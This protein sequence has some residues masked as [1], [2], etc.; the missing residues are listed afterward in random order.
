MRHSLP[1]RLES[2]NLG[3]SVRPLDHRS[4]SPS[5]GSAVLERKG[6]RS[7]KRISTF[8]PTIPALYIHRQDRKNRRPMATFSDVCSG[9]KLFRSHPHDNSRCRTSVIRS[10]NFS[11]RR[12]RCPR[13]FR[14]VCVNHVTLRFDKYAAMDGNSRSCDGHS[15]FDDR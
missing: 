9:Y 1:I 4:L 3:D 13:F 7:G 5:C 14:Q 11:S 12:S 15:Q 10:V 2:C 6:T 8:L